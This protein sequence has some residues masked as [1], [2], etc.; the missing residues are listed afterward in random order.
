MYNY[1]AE[2]LGTLFIVYV[3]FTTS[4]AIAIGLAY[5]LCILL[6]NGIGPGHFNPA[7]TIAMAASGNIPINDIIPYSFAQIL[8][9]FTAIQGYKMFPL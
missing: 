1:L 3:I 6:S 5:T 9:S 7:I 4:N 2:Y 8:G